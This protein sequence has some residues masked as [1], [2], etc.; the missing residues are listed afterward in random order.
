[1]QTEKLKFTGVVTI[2][3]Y[4]EQTGETL[5]ERVSRLV[6]LATAEKSGA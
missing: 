2:R 6:S 1:M 5:E 3:R 4:N